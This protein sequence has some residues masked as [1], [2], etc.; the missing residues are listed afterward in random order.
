MPL[1]PKQ[2]VRG[3]SWI[4][5]DRK[6]RVDFREKY[7]G[8]FD[9]F[10]DAVAA[11]KEAEQSSNP[12][13]YYISPDEEITQELLLRLFKYD[14]DTGLVTRKL[15]TSNE[16]LV[17]TVVGTKK[18]PVSTSISGKKYLLH[19]LIWVM[20]TGKWPDNVIDHINGDSTDNRWINLRDVPQRINARNSAIP[21]SNK[22][23]VIGVSW[24]SRTKS[25]RAQIGAVNLGRFKQLEDAKLARLQAEVD[26]EYHANHGRKRARNGKNN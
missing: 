13:T 14:P 9:D 26:S 3:V 21:Q 6:W 12:T 24:D 15:R 17:G 1:S 7:L 8:R 11:R 2:K 18:P 20:Q 23:G 16:Y 19:R 10:E 22:S 25:W 4:K 5:S